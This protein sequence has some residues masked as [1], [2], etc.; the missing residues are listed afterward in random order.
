MMTWR[1]SSA[2]AD[3]PRVDTTALGS[4]LVSSFFA[5]RRARQA[6]LLAQDPLDKLTVTNER[7]H[8]INDV[9]VFFMSFF[10]HHRTSN[11][12][13]V[14]LP[15]FSA[16]APSLTYC[17]HV[18]HVSPRSRALTIL[19]GTHG[20]LRRARHLREH[21]RG[22]ERAPRR[23][24][25]HHADRDLTGAARGRGAVPAAL[26]QAVA[27]A[28]DAR[29]EARRGACAPP[30]RKNRR[31]WRCFEMLFLGASCLL[32]LLFLMLPGIRGC[33]RSS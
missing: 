13:T 11:N 33:S 29:D 32:L 30:P 10:P 5:P 19:G 20:L 31:F 24:G 8:F 1:S 2:A 26:L 4:L 18:T 9:R 15:P 21:V 14:S 12:D 25:V 6:L 16:L 28:D 27:A 3:A 22:A 7:F 23:R 17:T